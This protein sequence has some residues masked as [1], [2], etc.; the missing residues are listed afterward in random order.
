MA[1]ETPNVVLILADDMGVG[2]ISA[3][4]ETSKIKTQHLDQLAKDGMIFRDAHSGAS[5]CTPTRYGLLTGRYAWRTALKEKVV[6]GYSPCIV[7]KNR[8]T[9]AH[10]FKE[11]GYKTAMIGKWHLGMDWS[12]KAGQS[13]HAKD[14]IGVAEAKVDFHKDIQHGPVQVGF[15][16]FEGVSASWDFPPYVFINGLKAESI[17]TVEVQGRQIAEDP[18]MTKG[19]E[20]YNS[21]HKALKNFLKRFPKAAWRKGLAA[22]GT[23][24]FSASEQITKR[25]VHYIKKQNGEQPFFLY[26]PLTAPHTPVAPQ[27]KFKGQSQCGDYGDFCLEVD[28]SVGQV[29]AALKE[30]GLYDNTIVIFTADN[31]ASLKAITPYDQKKYQ[32]RPSGPF[33]GFK[34]RLQEGGH[35]V[36]FIVSWP[37]GI[38]A[39]TTAEQAICLNDL[40]A[41]FAD[42]LQVNLEPNVAEDSFSF[43]PIL[44]GE[45]QGVRSPTIVHSAFNG[46]FALRKGPWKVIFKQHAKLGYQPMLYRLD[47]DPKEAKDLSKQHPEMLKQLEN[48][49]TQIIIKGRSTPG[50]RQKNVGEW[51]PQINWISQEEILSLY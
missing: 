26:M 33:D 3:L 27:S 5:V 16:H 32:H 13:I 49:M 6:H 7:E 46:E 14:D 10:L 23:D 37:K 38:S 8:M 50:P 2:D 43:Y 22:E 39:N 20:R 47:Q 1:R 12:T 17:P 15:D 42:M 36:P 51:W 31:G 45:L 41:T 24:V 40:M 21:D 30:R 11:Q 44:K 25:S 34:A 35:R 18:D 48:T 29:V 19:M 28:D 4:Y 9:L